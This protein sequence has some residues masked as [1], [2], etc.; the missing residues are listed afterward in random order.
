[1]TEQTNNGKINETIK[2]AVDTGATIE[3]TDKTVITVEKSGIFSRIGAAFRT[4]P[5]TSTIKTIAGLGA[6]G[7]AGY[8]A[9]AKLRD[10]ADAEDVKDAVEAA[11]SAIRALA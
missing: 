10:G 11:V 4:K 3:V 6:A 7:G 5:V 1:M 2:S 8:V 9:Y